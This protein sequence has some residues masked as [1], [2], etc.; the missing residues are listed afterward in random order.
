MT[1]P[2]PPHTFLR[3]FPKPKTKDYGISG[4]LLAIF[5]IISGQDIL[6]IPFYWCKTTKM[7]QCGEGTVFS[8][9]KVVNIFITIQ[10]NT[11]IRWNAVQSENVAWKS[12]RVMLISIY[13]QF[14]TVSVTLSSCMLPPK[15]RWPVNFM[16]HSIA[17]HFNRSNDWQLALLC[18][19]ISCCCLMFFFC[20]TFV[21][22]SAKM[23]FPPNFLNLS[24]TSIK[25][26]G[27]VSVKKMSKTIFLDFIVVII[28]FHK[29]N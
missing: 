25:P 7:I 9:N 8:S 3:S 22:S 23:Q 27:M 2:N 26:R 6:I 4:V 1:L 5:A 15:K 21:S 13:N 20:F 12:L 18:D 10:R 19:I 24:F 28:M 11:G 29:I 16:N 14:I 17:K